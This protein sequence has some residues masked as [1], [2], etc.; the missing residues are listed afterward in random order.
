MINAIFKFLKPGFLYFHL[1]PF[2][3]LAP[4]GA[5]F[6]SVFLL[7][8]FALVDPVVCLVAPDWTGRLPMVTLLC[9]AGGCLVES[10]A[11]GILIT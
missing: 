8:V 10:P 3:C 7:V 1:A 9:L 6:L 2:P 11:V 5:V 4:V